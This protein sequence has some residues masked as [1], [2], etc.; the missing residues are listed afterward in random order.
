MQLLAVAV[1]AA[2]LAPGQSAVR[3]S[4]SADLQAMSKSAVTAKQHEEVAKQYK[5]RAAEFAKKA[6]KHEKKAADLM[7]QPA[8]PIAHKWPAMQPKPWEKERQLAMQAR[9]AA[10]ESAQLSARHTQMAAQADAKPAD[11]E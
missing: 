2:V 10:E 3:S 9:R 8:P 7:A 11:V 6:E 5:D 4:D 1:F